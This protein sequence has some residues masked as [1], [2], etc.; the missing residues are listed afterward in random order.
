ML[1]SGF[2]DEIS[3]DFEEQL[4]AARRLGLSHI[5]LRGVDGQNIGDCPEEVISRRVLPLCQQYG[6]GVS[7]IGSPLGK[8]PLEDEAACRAQLETARRLCRFAQ[9]LDCHYVRV[10]SFY[11]PAGTDETAETAVLA[12]LRD[13]LDCFRGSGVTLLH[14]NEKGIY[15]ETPRR[16]LAL[17][18]ALEGEAFGLIYDPAN[19]VQCRVEPEAAFALLERYVR[20]IHIKDADGATGRNVVCGQ[21]DGKLPQLLR[22]LHR[23]GYDG[24]LTLEPHL[25]AFD[26]LA[27]LERGGGESVVDTARRRDPYAAFALQL[28]AVKRLY[29]E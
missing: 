26:G 15:G 14:E 9:A 13:L 24:F 27:G 29:T 16:C 19:F 6:I 25:V 22:Y 4:R 17:A 3:P 5:S 1:L 2:T 28:D 7:S 8:V 10:F 21:G 12:R 20:Y 23:T 18:Q 11:V